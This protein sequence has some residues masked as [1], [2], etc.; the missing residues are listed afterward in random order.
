[1]DLQFTKEQME[2]LQAVR[3]FAE[4]EVAEA[5]DQM[6]LH[7]TFPTHL[8]KRMAELGLMGIPIPKKWGGAE[9]DFISYVIAIHE[10]SKVSAAVGVILSV[11]TSVGTFPILRY[12]TNEQIAHYV[13]KLAAGEWLGAFALTESQAGSDAASIRMSAQFDGEFYIL[14]G[15]KQFITNAGAANTYITFAVTDRMQGT[16][17]I[18]AF[19]V[20]SGAEGLKVSRSENKMGLHGSNTCE[21][22]FDQ[23]KV[24]AAQ[25]LGL[26]G[27]GFAI[28]KG[29]LDG[30]RIGIAAQALGIAQA[31]LQLIERHFSIRSN[32]PFPSQ[33]KRSQPYEA[34]AQM[35][36]RVEAARLLVYHAAYLYQSGLPCTKEASTAKMFASDTAVS[37]T[38]DGVQLCGLTGCSKDFPLERL[39]RDAKATQIYEGTNEIH[40]IVISGKL[41]K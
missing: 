33:I 2:Y 41:L 32:H 40:R 29:A 31:A 24:S 35:T 34:L 16:R 1:M 30:G 13:P 26:E 6:E 36:A 5:V 38:G 22:V 23:V 17:G 11:H 19:I 8:I 39:F 25:R 28:A 37:V 21:L 18:T 14:N 7:H 10:I 9:S 27:E 20:E 3:L 12:G 15:V 4:T